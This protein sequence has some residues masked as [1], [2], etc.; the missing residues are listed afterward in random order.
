MPIGVNMQ[1]M[2]LQ[3]PELSLHSQLVIVS[4]AYLEQTPKQVQI[5][6]FSLQNFL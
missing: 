5:M 4:W 3:S 2:L 1:I 6:A